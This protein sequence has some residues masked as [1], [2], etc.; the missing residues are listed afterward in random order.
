MIKIPEQ[1]KEPYSQEADQNSNEEKPVKQQNILDTLDQFTTSSPQKPQKA[2]ENQED[3]EQELMEEAPSPWEEK[4]QF[5]V[6]EQHYSPQQYYP[7]SSTTEE[8]QE[9]AES[10]I[11]ER[12]QEF[13][14]RA[15][16][17]EIWKE[18]T[19]REIISMKQEI[20]RTQDR[21]NNLQKAVLGKV[22]EYNEN[23]LNIGTEMK[24]LEKVFEKILDPLVTNIKELERITNKL[25]K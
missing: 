6:I 13:M 18:R 4:T 17:F 5:P 14:A 3:A 12:W 7:Q 2:K 25:K 9:I 22:S 24:A 10:I 20:I 1:K 21:F 15:G 19:D 16:D 23:I 8:I 11:E